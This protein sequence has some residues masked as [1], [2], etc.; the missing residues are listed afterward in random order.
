MKTR[1]RFFRPSRIWWNSNLT[2]ATT[3]KNCKANSNNG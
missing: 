3:T 2:S 1:K